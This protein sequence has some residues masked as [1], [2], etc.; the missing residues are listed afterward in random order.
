MIYFYHE[1]P[2][3]KTFVELKVTDVLNF[4]QSGCHNKM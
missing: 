3:N 2:A 1:T 4:T